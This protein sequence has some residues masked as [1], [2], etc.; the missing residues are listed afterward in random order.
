MSPMK[1][2]IF[3]IAVAAL[4]IIGGTIV[5]VTL[6]KPTTT[7]GKV[8][9]FPNQ[10]GGSTSGG[11]SGTVTS[12]AAT[13]GG[14]LSVAGTPTVAPTVGLASL[15]ASSFLCNATGGGAVP[16]ACAIGTGLSFSG[17]TLNSSGLQAS[18]NLSDVGSAAT[19]LANL[20]AVPSSRTV[21]GTAPIQIGGGNSA[22]DLTANRVFSIVAATTSVAGSMSAADKA[23]VDA[24]AWQR[25]QWAFCKSKVSA[26]TGFEYM[27]VGQSADGIALTAN[28]DGAA[29]G[30]ALTSASGVALKLGATVLQTPAS[31]NY[32]FVFRAKYAVPAAASDA[33]IG[34]TSASHGIGIVAVNAVDTTHWALQLV[35]TGT[36]NLITTVVVDTLWH[37]FA[38]T[39]DGTTIT[40]WIDS[41]SAQSTATRTNIT[42]DTLAPY[43]FHNATGAAAASRLAYT[44]VA[45]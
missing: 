18:N 40:L 13:A 39:D 28:T 32:C 33:E 2:R 12:V 5:G 37:D 7:H 45:P 26:V 17:T 14:L 1:Q 22:L 23:F 19:S 24:Q 3:T 21:Q 31:G 29:E 6:P 8:G 9:A 11:G 35:G 43:L 10:W 36:T 16:T 44:F 4:V 38:V 25:T 30:G 15:A 34:M 27:K 42:T 41:V 20:G